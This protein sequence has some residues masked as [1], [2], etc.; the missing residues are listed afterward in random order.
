MLRFQFDMAQIPKEKEHSRRFLHYL[1]LLFF[2]T[3]D[4]KH[5]K[6]CF[7]KGNDCRFHI[8][9]KPCESLCI[10][11]ATN[12]IEGVVNDDPSTTKSYWY[13]HDGTHHNVCSFDI[14]TKRQAWDVFVNTNN[15]STTKIFGYNNNICIGNINT[16]YYCTLYRSKSNQEE[17]TYP[18][19][20]VLEAVAH[21]LKRLEERSNGENLSTRQIGL[22]TLLSGFNSHL[23]SC[24]V[25]ATMAWY[26]V[27][28][29]SRFYFSHDFKP[30]LLSQLESWFLGESFNR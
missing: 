11:F 24:V 9:K 27:V 14:C 4:W 6:G 15:P 30:L 25:S 23:S 21:R 18:Y 16:L 13:H 22:R 26:L 28:H 12:N 8:P 1:G 17:E 20:K 10:D 19:V 29:G 2:N 7:K 5:R 3:H